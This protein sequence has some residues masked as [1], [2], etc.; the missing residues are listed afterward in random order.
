MPKQSNAPKGSSRKVGR[1]KSKCDAYRAHGTRTKHKIKR[2]LQ[3]N[4]S[5]AVESYKRD[6]SK[7][8]PK[9]EKTK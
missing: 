1:N 2:I 6:P 8:F 3:S 4:G 9:Q 5:K 7:P